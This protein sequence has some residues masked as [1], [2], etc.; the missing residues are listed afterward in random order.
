MAAPPSSPQD[1]EPLLVS[2]LLVAAGL[3]ASRSEALRLIKSGGA[4]KNNMKVAPPD[5]LIFASDLH[6]G[7]YM[8][9]RKGKRH[10]A[11]V[12]FAGEPGGGEVEWVEAMYPPRI[13]I[14]PG[15]IQ[16]HP[17]CP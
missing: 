5:E 4:Y 17:L 16:D 3:C 8:L 14:R 13:E 15:C 11:V 6:H 7:Q 9:L 1:S 12:E 2:N 10:P